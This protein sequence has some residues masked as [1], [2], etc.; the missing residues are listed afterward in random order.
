MLSSPTDA[1]PPPSTPPRQP[2]FSPPPSSPPSFH[3]ISASICLH[4]AAAAAADFDYF[5]RHTLHFRR[6]MT[7]LMLTLDVDDAAAQQHHAAP[8]IL[9]FFRRAAATPLFDDFARSTP[10]FSLRRA[11]AAREKPMPPL[12]RCPFRYFTSFYID[13]R[14]IF[15]A[16]QHQTAARML[17]IPC[18]ARPFAREDSA[19][20][21]YFAPRCCPPPLLR[22]SAAAADAAPDD[23]NER[24][25]A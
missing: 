22:K 4:A 3:F 15:F 5:P 16:A 2:P 23:V 9:P 13:L 14:T 24:E 17:P 18:H 10:S 19:C 20:T 7:R 12:R 11:A 6:R 21:F 25:A 8:P 1:T